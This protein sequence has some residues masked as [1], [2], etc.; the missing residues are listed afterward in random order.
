MEMIIAV[1]SKNELC[2][3]EKVEFYKLCQ[4]MVSTPHSPFW[5]HKLSLCTVDFNNG[6]RYSSDFVLGIKI[7]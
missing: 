4:K 2:I 5:R 1:Q 6:R 7:C 3:L